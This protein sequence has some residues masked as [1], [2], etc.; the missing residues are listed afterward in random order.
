MLVVTDGQP[1]PMVAV[2]VVAEPLVLVVMHKQRPQAIHKLA[3]MVA[4][5]DIVILLD[6]K[7]GM[8]Q[9]VADRQLIMDKQVLQDMVVLVYQD[10]TQLAD[11]QQRLIQDQVQA[12]MMT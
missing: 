4:T 10:K 11:C 5:D 6:T 1:L 8:V 2:A 7:Y 9:A 12:P 3:E